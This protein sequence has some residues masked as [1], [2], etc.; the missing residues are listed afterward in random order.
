MSETLMVKSMYRF[1]LLLDSSCPRRLEDSLSVVWSGMGI[2]EVLSISLL[3][4]NCNCSE[5]SKDRYY[6]A[7][8]CVL[9]VLSWFSCLGFGVSCSQYVSLAD[10]VPG[11]SHKT[12]CA[13]PRGPTTIS[14]FLMPNLVF[15]F[16]IIFSGA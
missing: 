1:R 6:N 11:I 2:V 12:N 14:F 15:N 5:P 13:R 7:A 10:Q 8:S 16:H 3:F 4:S 9:V